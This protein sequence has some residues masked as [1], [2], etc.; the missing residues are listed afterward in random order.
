MTLLP[1][2]RSR[3]VARCRVPST[4]SYWSGSGV[5]GAEQLGEEKPRLSRASGRTD[6]ISV[7]VGTCRRRASNSPGRTVPIAAIIGGQWRESPTTARLNDGEVRRVAASAAT[8]AFNHNHSP[9]LTVS[10]RKVVPVLEEG[11][12][13][14]GS[15][16]LGLSGGCDLDL[17]TVIWDPAMLA[18]ARHSDRSCPACSS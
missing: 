17:P 5:S 18:D 11:F 3:G 1:S 4:G 2:S 9:S 15:D 10:T 6:Y 16:R 13:I 14:L 8:Y 12:A 7:R